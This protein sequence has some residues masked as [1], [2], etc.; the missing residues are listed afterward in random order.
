MSLKSFDQYV[1]EQEIVSTPHDPRGVLENVIRFLKNLEP[2]EISD[3]QDMLLELQKLL[4]NILSGS[5]F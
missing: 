3:C 5:D 4:D 2:K 1:K